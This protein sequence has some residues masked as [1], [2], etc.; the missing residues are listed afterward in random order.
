MHLEHSLTDLVLDTAY[1]RWWRKHCCCRSLAPSHHSLLIMYG[2]CTTTST[3]QQN[4]TARYT[5]LAFHCL[6]GV[7]KAIHPQLGVDMQFQTRLHIY[8]CSRTPPQTGKPTLAPP[9][10]CIVQVW[11]MTALHHLSLALKN[12]TGIVKMISSFSWDFWLQR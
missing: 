9:R 3:I 5:T 2:V 4:C 12:R 8:G 7:P 1:H 10:F 6:A 11:L